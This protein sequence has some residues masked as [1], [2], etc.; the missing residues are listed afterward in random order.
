VIKKNLQINTCFYNLPDV[1]T[2][3]SESTDPKN[4]YFIEF[5]GPHSRNFLGKS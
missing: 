4:L 5:L 2:L 1:L 3:Q